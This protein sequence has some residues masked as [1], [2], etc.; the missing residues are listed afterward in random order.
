M[1]TLVVRGCS[2][3]LFSCQLWAAS[4]HQVSLPVTSVELSDADACKALEQVMIRVTANPDVLNNLHVQNMC[5]KARETIARIEASPTETILHFNEQAIQ[6]LA[7]QGHFAQWGSQRPQILLWGVMADHHDTHFVNA[8]NEP[9]ITDAILATAQQ[10]GLNLHFPLYDLTDTINVSEQDVW[11]Q[12][13]SSLWEASKRYQADILLVAK[14]QPV[15]TQWQVQ[16]QI[17]TAEDKETIE[18]LDDAV[19]ASQALTASLA[20][21]L[22]PLYGVKS[23]QSQHYLVTI[24]GVHS[25]K[26]FADIQRLLNSLDT[27]K[28]ASIRSVQAH[29]ATFSVQS[30]AQA[31]ADLVRHLNMQQRFSPLVTAE[32]RQLRYQWVP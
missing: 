16:W 27:V 26:D 6:E 29:E 12:F 3:A 1:F 10:L 31:K 11:G 14:W 4:L 13:P 32:E 28:Q 5:S 18:S 24:S 30:Q 2:L 21:K 15:G 9:E 17:L 8:I 22:M 20:Q 7:L 25:S 19:G 23:Q